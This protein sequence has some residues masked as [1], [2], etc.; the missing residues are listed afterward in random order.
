MD[1]PIADTLGPQEGL[2]IGMGSLNLGKQ[3][4]MP[5]AQSGLELMLLST[6]RSFYDDD[7]DGDKYNVLYLWC[8]TWYFDMYTLWN[9]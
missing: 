8:T 7:D 2:A 4:I 6:Y 3:I 1:W 9:G 5:E